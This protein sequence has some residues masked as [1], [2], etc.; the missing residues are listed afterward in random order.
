[1]VINISSNGYF[2]L[3]VIIIVKGDIKEMMTQQINYLGTLTIMKQLGIKP[4]FSALEREYG[5]G[6]HT[7][8]KYYNNGG[9]TKRKKVIKKC[10]YDHLDK[11]IIVILENKCVN[12]SA[13][14]QYFKSKYPNEDINYN[15]LKSH[16]HR[17]G[18]Y[19]GKNKYIPHVR[20]ETNPG[21]QLQFDWKENIKMISKHGELF[22]FNIF[23]ATLGYSR[24]HTFIY[25][26]TRTTEDLLRCLIETLNRIGGKP[27]Y[28]KTDNM[29]SIVSITNGYKEKHNIIKQFEKDMNMKI[30]LCKTRTPETKGKVESSNRFMNWLEPYN[31]QFE[32]EEDLIKI[33]E[34]ITKQCNEVNNQTTNIPPIELFKKKKEYL[35]PLPQKVLLENYIVNFKVQIVPPTLLIHYKGCEYSVPKSYIN[36]RVKIYPIVNKLYIY[37][38]TELISIHEIK[39]QKINYHITDYEGGLKDNLKMNTDEEITNMSEKN[40]KRF[41]GMMKK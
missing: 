16:I 30:N 4:N 19:P 21:E 37:F 25:S 35:Q 14:A 20:Y 32:S 22:E 15:T 34:A 27:I 5:I 39:Q 11:E 1:M 17:L 31:N 36:K 8:R 38:N 33:I 9:K 6:R 12:M 41:E 2:F 28:C 29:S 13:L 23:S 7:L 40:L 10:K 3:Y 18:I 26:K 24:F